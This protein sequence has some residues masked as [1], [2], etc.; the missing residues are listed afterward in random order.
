MSLTKMPTS[1]ESLAGLSNMGFPPFGCWVLGVRDWKVGA[2]RFCFD[3]P[4]APSTQPLVA[5]TTLLDQ[6]DFVAGRVFDE[7]DHRAA[8]LH[9][10]GL[11]HDLDPFCLELGARLVDVIHAYGQVTESVAQ[12]VT[13]RSPVIG[14]LNHRIVLLVAVADKRQ[15]EFAAGVVLVAQELH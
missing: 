3:Q 8:V 14:Q 11:T 5:R 1:T 12:L 13:G 9:R 4:L 7:R 2:L 15:S 6:L 10:P